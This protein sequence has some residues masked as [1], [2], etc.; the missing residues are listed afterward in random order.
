MNCPSCSS[1]ELFFK[2][3]LNKWLCTDCGE[4]FEAPPV[5]KPTAP[6]LAA[7]PKRIFFSYGHDFNKPLVDR[8][9]ADLEKRGHSVWIDYKQL[10]TWDDWKGGITRGIHDSQLAVAFLSVHSTRDPG[11][12]RNEVAMALH[13]FG[14]VYPV[15]LEKVPWDSIPATIQH[16]QW[17]DLSD[18]N[19]KQQV[20]ASDFE[21]FYEERLLEIINKVEGEATRF[22]SEAEVLRRVLNPASFDGKFSQHLDGFVGREWLFE[23]FDQWVNHNPESRVFWLKAGPGFGKTA[24]AVNLANRYRA[25][26]VGTWFCEQGSLELTNPVRAVQTIAF[27]LALR[28]DDYRTRL[29][30]R[31]GLLA[32]SGEGQI[33]EAIENL[34]KKNLADT[35]SHLI[36]EPTAGLIWREHKLVI[37]MDA[38]DEATDEAGRNE[39]SALIS[40]RFLEL[41]KW[42]SFVAT[43]RPDASVV[44]HLQR[45][46]PFEIAAEDNRNTADLALYCAR[47]LETLPAVAAMDEAARQDLFGELVN[48]SSG[49][50]LYLRMV[51]DGL[52]EGSL[53][54]E[55]LSQM[56][57]GLGGL[58]SRYYSAFEHRFGTHYQRTVQPLLR[59]V[60]AAPGPLPLALAAEVLGCG[61]EEAQKMRLQLGAYVVEGS[62][63]LSLFHKTLG[64][65]LGSEASG[66]FLTDGESAQRMLGE[67]LWGCFEGRR[68]NSLG[69]TERLPWEKLILTWLPKL[70]SSIGRT[71]S[72][73]DLVSLAELLHERLVW[74]E[75]ESLYK[76]A[77][78]SREK[79]QGPGHPETLKTCVALGILLRD[80][81]QYEAAEDLCRRALEGLEKALGAEHPDTLKSANTLAVLLLHEGDY[82]EAEQLF[83]QVLAGYEKAFGAGHP[84]TLKILT[85]LGNLLRHTSDYVGAEDLLK[86][87]LEG[88][89]RMF[90]SKHPD[91]L[92]SV[93][94]LA[95]LLICKGDY[96][97]AETLYRRAIEGREKALGAEHPDTLTSVNNLGIL[98]SHKEAYD[99]AEALYRRAIEGREKALGAEHPDT[100]GSVKNLGILLHCKGEY[101]AAEALLERSA[102]SDESPVCAENP[103]TLTSVKL[104]FVSLVSANYESSPVP[105]RDVSAPT[106]TAVAFSEEEFT[107][108]DFSEEEFTEEDFSEEDFAAQNGSDDYD[109]GL[110]D[111]PREDLL[112]PLGPGGAFLGDQVHYALE[113]H[114]GKGRSI[115]DI[116]GGLA[117]ADEWESALTV[118]MDSEI[119]IGTDRVR[120]RDVGGSAIAER[121]F[122]IPTM[123][124]T[125]QN[126]SERLLLDRLIADDSTRRAWA[127]SIA[128]WQFGFPGY[129]RSFIDLIFEKNGRWYAVDYKTN[130]LG[131]YDAASIE[132][133]MLGNHY[134]LQSR[135]Y[136]VALHR[137]L[138][139]NLA[140][141]DPDLHFGGVLFL[142]VRGMPSEGVWFERPLPST[143]QSLSDLFTPVRQ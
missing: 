76:R 116:A 81:G 84:D 130:R 11:V 114:L 141:Y 25:T 45:F 66:V 75:A 142:F 28:W 65:W 42:I 55:E 22:A 4:M 48:K 33:K 73:N 80:K 135:F 110:P 108:E 10:G 143:L 97:E 79:A 52:Q 118:I 39:L 112:S 24:F 123:R 113:E 29:L 78:E 61:K 137:Y 99:A 122:I 51:M 67:F 62:G 132:A 111:Y 136:C 34:A 117:P 1:S 91:T 71:E 3:K 20:D 131:S 89:E 98:L 27:Q 19:E 54:L 38:L 57:V 16:L 102:V 140:N 18:W 95:N 59:L 109:G 104:S 8:F 46:K 82:L 85:S 58:Y 60:I 7:N 92:T 21:R 70:L 40:G 121:Y 68:K 36:S 100:L 83:R 119:P 9:K 106:E 77:L 64:E 30:P 17:P 90:G 139:E 32:G 13:Y 120:L 37:L 86:R 94:S 127:E 93:N 101:D 88:S 15:L 129:F 56:E 134:L 105:D 31:L 5:E 14:M 44:V 133:S 74:S 87:A 72:S 138:R 2:A 125:P 6:A 115:A 69:V 53:R 43:S 50:V 41:P 107:E 128:G 23:E 35:F 96:D 63:G 124:L 49:M 103:D 47:G 126:L 12:C 26:V